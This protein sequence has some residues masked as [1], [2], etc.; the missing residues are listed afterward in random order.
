M[1]VNES[2]RNELVE[3]IAKTEPNKNMNTSTNL[4]GDDHVFNQIL[5]HII[6]Q[7][8]SMAQNKKFRRFRLQKAKDEQNDLEEEQN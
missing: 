4:N 1:K 3:K 2:G 8:D 5:E 7:N 6:N